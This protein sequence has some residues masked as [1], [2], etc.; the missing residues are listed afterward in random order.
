MG[1]KGQVAV[2]LGIN[3]AGKT[4][5]AEIVENETTIKNPQLLK[6]LME[7]VY[8]IQFMPESSAPE[9]QI[10]KLIYTFK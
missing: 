10:G 6:D 7:L 1:E 4:I 9:E 5:N 3:P 2:K 8:M